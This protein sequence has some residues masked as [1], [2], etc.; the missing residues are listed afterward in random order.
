MPK[1]TLELTPEIFALMMAMQDDESDAYGG[2]PASVT[3]KIETIEPVA[4]LPWNDCAPMPDLGEWIKASEA[5][6]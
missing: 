1:M 5:Q 2:S 4:P 6:F 3:V